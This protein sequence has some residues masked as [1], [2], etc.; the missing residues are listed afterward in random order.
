MKPLTGMR[1]LKK[2]IE[3]L[4]VTST[5]FKA[6]IQKIIDIRPEVYNE[7]QYWTPLK[8]IL[9]N[10]SLNV[11]TSI[12]SKTPIFKRSYY[13]DLFAGSGINKIKSSKDFLIGSPL[14]A[15]LN[16]S[17]SYTS[18]IFSEI[19]PKF[20]E[21]LRLRLGVLKKNNLIFMEKACELCIGDIL[22]KVNRRETYSFFFID[23]YGMEFSWE[24]M[25]KILRVRSDILLTFMSSEIYRAVGLAKVGKSKGERITKF[26]GDNSWEEANSAEELVEIYKTKILNERLNAPIRIIKVQSKRFNF[27]YHMFFI[28]NRTSGNNKWLRAIDKA[29]GEIESNSD[30]AVEKTLDIVKKRQLE[31]STFGDNI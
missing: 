23:P 15:S 12:I 8:L 11:C 24:S 7:F 17:E 5:R 1:W 14:I 2:W 6:E 16:H 31:L 22:D 10:Y 28:T 30:I 19:D 18:L 20:N 9:L 21:A 13:I 29:K 25:K 4:E 27:S 3:K 26:F